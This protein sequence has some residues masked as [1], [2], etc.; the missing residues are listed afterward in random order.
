MRRET[1]YYRRLTVHGGSRTVVIPREALDRWGSPIPD[2]VM[3][4]VDE[5]GKITI[6][7]A[8][9]ALARGEAQP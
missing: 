3:L 5:E 8:T 4:A 9:E 1:V 7:P 2:Y 6:V